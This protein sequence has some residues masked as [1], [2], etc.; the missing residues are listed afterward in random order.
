MQISKTSK[1]FMHITNLAKMCCGP[2]ALSAYICAA[3]CLSPAAA[4]ESYEITENVDAL[5]QQADLTYDDEE[6]PTDSGN[7]LTAELEDDGMTIRLPNG[8]DL[9]AGEV[10]YAP[11]KLIIGSK[12]TTGSLLIYDNAT[13]TIG[14]NAEKAGAISIFNRDDSTSAASIKNASISVSQDAEGNAQAIFTSNENKSTHATMTKAHIDLTQLKQGATVTIDDITISSSQIQQTH[15]SLHLVNG[16]GVSLIAES[17]VQNV[18]VDATSKFYGSDVFPG[19]QLSGVNNKV[20][21]S[22]L[23]GPGLTAPVTNGAEIGTYQLYGLTAQAGTQITMNMKD[24]QFDASVSKFGGNFKIWVQGLNWAPLDEL[25]NNRAVITDSKIINNLFVLT[26]FN[27]SFDADL[28]KYLTITG[29][30]YAGDTQ[31]VVVEFTIVVPEPTTATLSLLAL[32]ALA[33][34]RRRRI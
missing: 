1:A 20:D 14:E 11:Q 4:E 6:S 23:E 29:V 16:A 25:N 31:G 33:A 24:I 3:I 9:N 22:A 13:L 34:R 19:V 30:T 21:L 15:G 12:S 18:Y 26:D 5:I 32:S 17:K 28:V 8:W 10:L 2:I 27:S 7:N